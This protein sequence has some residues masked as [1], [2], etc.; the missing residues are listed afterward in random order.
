MVSSEGRIDDR[1]RASA[2]DVYICFDRRAV[3]DAFF[4]AIN[5]SSVPD[6]ILKRLHLMLH[7]SHILFFALSL[8]GGRGELDPRFQL[9]KLT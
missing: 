8:K 3:H 6:S 2:L 4:H 7:F 1:V 5:T 9:H